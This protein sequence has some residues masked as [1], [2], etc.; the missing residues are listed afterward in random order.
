MI[1]KV[2]D[3]CEKFYKTL[4]LEIEYFKKKCPSDSDI[5]SIIIVEHAN[6]YLL[7]SLKNRADMYSSR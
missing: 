1:K 7:A 2:V 5:T 4:I 6:K 3:D